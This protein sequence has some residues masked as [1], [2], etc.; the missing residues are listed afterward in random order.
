VSKHVEDLQRLMCIYFGV[1]KVGYKCN[2]RFSYFSLNDILSSLYFGENTYS[3]P[4]GENPKWTVWF[5]MQLR[6]LICD[7]SQRRQLN[8][9]L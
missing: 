9:D 8:W 3:I 7:F 4:E 1:Y 2:K 5:V 6:R